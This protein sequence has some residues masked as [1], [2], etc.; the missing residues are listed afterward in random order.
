MSNNS[1]KFRYNS[2]YRPD[3]SAIAVK[4]GFDRP[5]LEVELNESQ[6]IQNELRKNVTRNLMPS[7]FTEIVSKNFLAD[8]IIYNPVSS[9]NNV[10]N[11]IAIA[12]CKAVVN[13]YI[14]NLTGNF[15]TDSASDYILLNLGDPP[16]TGTREDLVYLEVWFEKVSYQDDFYIKNVYSEIADYPKRKVPYYEDKK[17]YESIYKTDYLKNLKEENYN[18]NK[19]QTLKQEIAKYEYSENPT[20]LEMIQDKTL[21]KNEPYIRERL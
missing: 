18:K 11:A 6:D 19:D 9:Y 3:S 10:L 14:I 4:Y 15:S 12:P 20:A 16:Y 7:G 5:L 21:R 1:E 2:A 13:G 17:R 8:P